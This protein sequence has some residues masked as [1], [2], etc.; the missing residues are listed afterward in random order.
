MK[1]LV[2]TEFIEMVE[3]TFSDEIADKILD[4][5][6]LASNGVYTSLGTYDHHEMLELV[7]HLS[8]ETG[9]P[10][11]ELVQAFGQYLFT[12]FAIGFPAMINETSDTFSL[13]KRIEGYIHVEVRKL[14]S[15]A[16]LP[17]FDFQMPSDGQMI[18]DYQSERPFAMLA[19]GLISQAIVHYNEDIDLNYEDLS[20]GAGTS[21]RF[22]L[23]KRT[24]K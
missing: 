2:F 14:Y 12:R 4:E 15:D 20:D 6:D 13:L 5:S 11:P 18:L 8:K 16:Q 9:I 1:G 21:A 7:T 19:H 3:N 22:I 17:H 23:T 24:E 10:V